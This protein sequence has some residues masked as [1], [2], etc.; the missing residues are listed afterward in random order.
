MTIELALVHVFRG[1]IPGSLWHSAPPG[2]PHSRRTLRVP[3]IRHGVI[4][5]AGNGGV[6][7]D[8]ATDRVQPISA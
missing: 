4:E 6:R 2:S 5:P 1:T 8:F 3:A 7:F